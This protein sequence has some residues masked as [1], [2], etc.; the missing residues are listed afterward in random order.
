M[1]AEYPNMQPQ[2]YTV[3]IHYIIA[4]ILGLLRFGKREL[5]T[6]IWASRL[7]RYYNRNPGTRVPSDKVH[8]KGILPSEYRFP[9]FQIFGDLVENIDS[10]LDPDTSICSSSFY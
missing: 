9:S 4:R 1:T 2:K 6:G 8:Q 3:L 7:L 5:C 10:N